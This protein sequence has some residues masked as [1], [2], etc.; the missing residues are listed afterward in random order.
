M[1]DACFSM[2]MDE[3]LDLH[4]EWGVPMRTG[5]RN[6][7]LAPW[8]TFGARD[9]YVIVCVAAN[10]QW[11]AFLQAIDR[12]D[13]ADDPRFNSPEG[14][15]KNSDEIEELV[16]EWIQPLTK[17]EALGR[18][19]QYK[20]PCEAVPEIGEVFDDPQLNHRGMILNLR[21]PDSGPTGVKTA[22]FPVRL[23][24]TRAGLDDAAPFPGGHNRDVY[25]GLLGLSEAELEELSR[26]G[27]I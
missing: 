8:N 26:A 15:F 11:Q 21:H 16:K 22:G 3:A 17:D 25:G 1:Q 9:G 24:E 12:T 13:L 14:R 20:V 7:R 4:L 19:R 2:I 18:L 10:S 5:N 6:P 23:T 27:I